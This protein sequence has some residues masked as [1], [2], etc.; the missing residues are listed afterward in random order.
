MIRPS[1]EALM[2]ER[3]EQEIR[4]LEIL[5]VLQ[6]RRL[7]ILVCLAGVLLPVFL[8]NQVAPRIYQAQ[9]TIIFQEQ[10]EAIPTFDFSEAFTRQ[11]Y[12]VNQIEEIKSRTL[13]EE[14]VDLLPGEIRAVLLPRTNG[15]TEEARREALTKAVRG[16]IAAQPVRNSDVIVIKVQATKPK[17]AAG[18]ANAVAEVVKRRNVAVKREKASSTRKFIEE[19]LPK[20]EGA[21]RKDEEALSAFKAHNQVVSLSDE[22]KE[23]LVRTTSVATEHAKAQAE[24]RAAEQRLASV[25]AQMKTQRASVVPSITRT[26]SAWADTLRKKLVSLEVEYTNLLVKGYGTDHPQMKKLT[27]EIAQ[28]KG[29]LAGEVLRVAEGETLGDPMS[30][31][32]DL[33]KESLGLEIDIQTDST[34]EASLRTVLD[35]YDRQMERL[36]NKELLLLRLTRSQQVNDNIYRLLLE[37]FEEARITEA[38]Q[39]GNVRVIDTAKEPRSPI[40]PRRFQNL[41]LALIVGLTL[42]GGL[43]FFTESLDRSI[44]NP[45]EA[46]ALLGIPVI[47][48]IPSIGDLDGKFKGTRNEIELISSRLVTHFVPRSPVAEAY[49]TVR[50]N[51][52]FSRP[53]NPPRTILVTSAVPQEGK[54]TTTANLA[55]TLAQMG[56]KTLIVDSD[57][58]R[59]AIRKVFNLESKEGLTDYLIGKGGLDALIRTTDIPNLYILPAGQIPPNP[60]EVLGSQRMKEL[61]AELSRRFEMVF[62]D[63][64]PVVAV[65]DAAV[66]SRNTDG[67]VLVVQS[68]ATD[69]EAVARAKTLLG[70]VQANLL[71]L[72]LNN[73]RIESTYGSYH[74]RYYYHYYDSEDGKK[75]KGRH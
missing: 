45:E 15:L 58:R 4:P 47:G 63:S 62:F 6:R 75:R 23:L 39:I 26:T 2:D 53:D 1:K 13:S 50:T 11:S 46:E 28:T 14:V 16:S 10:R 38:G 21:L 72:V 68:G 40:K 22:A 9:T 73:I 20:V 67:V 51:L 70:N 41:L 65:T 59:P 8:Y 37:R 74:Y 66:L 52:S 49:R 24:R 34:R 44:K 18:V 56:G 55:I 35:S 17:A 64:P 29:Q 30:R 61:V 54:T 25:R 32:A 71:G 43:A 48:L 27:R 3:Q 31:L 12:L 42:G 19:Q 36:P 33:S 57:L 69:R 5:A 7:L 60:S